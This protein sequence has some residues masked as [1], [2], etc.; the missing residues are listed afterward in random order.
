MPEYVAPLIVMSSPCQLHSSTC[1]PH[2]TFQLPCRQRRL[3][4]SLPVR[5]RR[6]RIA[7]TARTAASSSDAGHQ[8]SAA[9]QPAVPEG[10]AE[11][12]S[13]EQVLSE[14]QRRKKLWFAAVKPP[15][16]TVSIIPIV[17]RDSAAP[18]CLQQGSCVPVLAHSS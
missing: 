3:S 9:A 16:Y 6:K 12:M 1:D 15:M 17:V 8:Q 11:P 5:S 14:Q 13:Q 18:F 10:I 2:R 7:Q 4:N